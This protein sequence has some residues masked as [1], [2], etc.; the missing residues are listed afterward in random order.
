MMS[1]LFILFIFLPLSLVLSESC[2]KACNA[3]E[4]DKQFC[5]KQCPHWND[6]CGEACD[7]REGYYA[8]SLGYCISKCPHWNASKWCGKFC[9]N[10]EG[11]ASALGYCVE[12]CRWDTLK[13]C[14]NAC[15]GMKGSARDLGNCIGDC[16]RRVYR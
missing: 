13:V 5:I 12:L 3:K 11:D 8:T 15:K 9:N 10:R 14:R 2:K 6:A 16:R 1:R 4:G 7:K